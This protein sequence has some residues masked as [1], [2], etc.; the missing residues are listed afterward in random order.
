MALIKCSECG[1]EI[2]DKALACPNCGCPIRVAD[3]ADETQPK[4]ARKVK[5]LT[6]IIPAIVLVAA[7][8]AGILFFGR[9]QLSPIE[10]LSVSCVQ[11]IKASLKDRTSLCLTDDIEVLEWGGFSPKDDLSYNENGEGFLCY[12]S[13]PY[14]A[15]NSYGARVE[16]VAYFFLQKKDDED[17]F[18]AKYAGDWNDVADMLENSNY[19]DY[20]NMIGNV[21]F[22]FRMSGKIVKEA[23]SSEVIAKQVGCDVIKP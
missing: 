10:Q 23:I 12:L 1:R 15:T 14:S 22:R 21:A 4:S 19:K 16:N 13:V 2:S 5:P 20:N 11:E 17:D 18:S 9:T 6:I 3:N 7:V 8:I